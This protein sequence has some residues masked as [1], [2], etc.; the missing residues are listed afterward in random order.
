LKLSKL[1]LL[2]LLIS[3][4]PISNADSNA[5][6]LGVDFLEPQNGDVLS[7]PF[8]VRFVVKGMDLRPAGDL[9]VNTGH[10]HLLI[11]SQTI[12]VGKMV[13]ANDTHIHFGKGQTETTLDLPKG[14]HRLTLQFA[15]GVHESY[16]DVM[17]KTI[18]ISVQ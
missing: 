7:S 9:T 15:N 12:E 1:I 2:L 4:F 17:S 16:G 3:N 5:E 6:T 18:E 14:Q 8:K 10:H 13:P 11:N